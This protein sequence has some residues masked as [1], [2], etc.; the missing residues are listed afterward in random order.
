MEDR[1]DLSLHKCDKLFALE[2]IDS[3]N[4]EIY[5]VQCPKMVKIESMIGKKL[6]FSDSHTTTITNTLEASFEHFKNEKL[7]TITNFKEYGRI[8]TIP[9]AGRIVLRQTIPEVEDNL[10]FNIKSEEIVPF[11][12]NLK[13]RHPLFGFDY[14][15]KINLPQ[16]VLRKL[17]DVFYNRIKIKKEK[18]SKKDKSERGVKRRRQN[19]EESQDPQIDE[20]VKKKKKLKKEKLFESS[21]YIE[22]KFIEEKPLKKKKG[23]V[24][25]IKVEDGEHDISND[26]EWLTQ[27]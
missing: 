7:L 10:E 5:I 24:S 3:E 1:P 26:L 22:D 16:D 18:R 14:E 17:D 11:P 20:P 21:Q 19:N 6:R 2:N 13:K 15:S 4:E 23:S 27:I 9:A 12:K 8:K 25:R